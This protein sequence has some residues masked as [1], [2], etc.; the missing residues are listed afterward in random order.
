MAEK[1]FDISRRDTTMAPLKTTAILVSRSSG[2]RSYRETRIGITGDRG[3]DVP[4]FTRGG[5]SLV[6]PAPTKAT[7]ST[8]CP[9]ERIVSMARFTS[10]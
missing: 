5:L 4:R 7:T 8:I 3:V 6:N 10:G 9:M 2:I 1:G